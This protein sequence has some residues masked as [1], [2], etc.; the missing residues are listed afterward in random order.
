M[1]DELENKDGS[2]HDPERLDEWGRLRSRVDAAEWRVASL[3]LPMPNRLEAYI[4]ATKEL[5]TAENALDE[6]DQ[7][8]WIDPS[9]I[10]RP[11]GAGTERV[12]GFG[13]AT[14]DIY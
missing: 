8:F 1:A 11:Y 12:N 9:P 14:V 4:E 13:T 2:P 10:F 6:F 7:Q 5:D 3:G